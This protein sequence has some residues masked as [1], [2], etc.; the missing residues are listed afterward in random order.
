MFMMDLKNLDFFFPFTI[1][2]FLSLSIYFFLTTGDNPGYINNFPMTLFEKSQIGLTLQNNENDT[3]NK[4]EKNEN[5]KEKED[6]KKPENEQQDPYKYCEI[7]KIEK[8]LRM[9]HCDKCEICV[10]KFDHHCF[11]I[12]F[13]D[14][15]F[16]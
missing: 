13:F 4:N 12:G 2:L 10:H 15:F 9:K 7:C 5:E 6:K 11:W 1:F 3:N 16:F 8:Y 14:C